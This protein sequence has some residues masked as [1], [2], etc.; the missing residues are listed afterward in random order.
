MIALD[1]IR[2]FLPKYLSE[3]ST[4]N[5][6]NQLN[7]F[8]LNIDSRFYSN[9]FSY[10][11][12]ILQGDGLDGMLLVNL[13]DMKIGEGKAIIISNSCDIDSSNPR[14]VA[15]SICYCPI[16]NLN[17]YEVML[18]TKYPDLS[19]EKIPQHIQDIR[20][21]RV[22]QIFFLPALG[23]LKE[24]SF[25]FFDRICSYDSTSIDR[26]SLGSKKI[27][28]LSNYGFYLFLFK[29]SIH[30]TRIRESVDRI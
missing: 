30:F 28:T 18:K 20:A 13:P 3:E 29:L 5:L 9:I 2:I 26:T 6:F 16:F 19:G 27:F 23:K 21:Q 15:S 11:N 22:S 7:Q 8:P 14:L 17:K 12:N 25:F 10:Q 4:I 1:D 24:D